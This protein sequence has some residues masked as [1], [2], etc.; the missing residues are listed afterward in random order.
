MLFFGP[1]ESNNTAT[2]TFDTNAQSIMTDAAITALTN[3]LT[4]R[5]KETKNFL[6]MIEK[7]D[8]SSK[9]EATKEPSK[10]QNRKG[11][12]VVVRAAYSGPEDYF[13]IPDG[14]DLADEKVVKGWEI[15]WRELIIH[16]VD[17]RVEQICAFQEFEVDEKRPQ[18]AEIALVEDCG[19]CGDPYEEDD[20]ADEDEAE[21]NYQVILFGENDTEG[22]MYEFKDL[23]F[24]QC[25]RGILCGIKTADQWKELG[26]IG[27]KI[28][29]HWTEDGE[30]WEYETVECVEFK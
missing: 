5:R 22:Q 3:K 11:N 21:E 26:Y 18:E 1:G 27:V 23:M 10:T 13:K 24:A 20:E 28:E 19:L 17:G 25:K 8:V 14:L 6:K 15:R 9:V 4:A 29:R 12:R 7:S 30:D 2:Q 16:Y